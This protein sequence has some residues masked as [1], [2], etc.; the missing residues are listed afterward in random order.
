MSEKQGENFDNRWI[1]EQKITEQHYRLI[2]QIQESLKNWRKYTISID[3]VFGSGKSTLARFLA[4]QLGMPAIETDMFLIPHLGEPL[5]RIDEMTTIIME[6]HNENRPVIIE[7]ILVL[8]NLK[9]IGIKSDFK[10]FVKNPTFEGSGRLESM[11][12]EYQKQFKVHEEVDF[13]FLLD[14]DKKLD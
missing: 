11:I 13:Y 9:D 1:P 7:G 12:E 5:Y 4:W 6:R 3:G 10:V 8:K 2:S 14:E